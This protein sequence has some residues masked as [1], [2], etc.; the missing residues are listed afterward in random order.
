MKQEIQNLSGGERQRLGL[1]IGRLIKR[2]IWL[3]DEPVSA[4]DNDNKILI[5][6]ML[7]KLNATVIIVSHDDVWNFEP[8]KIHNINGRS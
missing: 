7:S 4:L 5:A 6:K 2:P 1:V 8:F 3:L